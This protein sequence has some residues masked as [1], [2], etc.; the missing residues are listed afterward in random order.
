MD[1]GEPTV[2][3]SFQF[4]T[5]VSVIEISRRGDTYTTGKGKGQQSQPHPN[6]H[7]SGKQRRILK[8]FENFL[9]CILVI[10]TPPPP[11]ISIPTS[12]LY[13]FIYL[14]IY[15]LFNFRQ[16]LAM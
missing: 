3:I 2:F 6:P 9:Q 7:P 13:L 14:P 8:F 15:L 4:S 12:R 16:G 1:T 5:S 11:P 10:F